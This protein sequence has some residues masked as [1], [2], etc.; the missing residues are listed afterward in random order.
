MNKEAY[1]HEIRH[2]S[3]HLLAAAVKSIWPNAK[4]A[5]VPAIVLTP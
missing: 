3:A 5:I 4:N 2:S 1:L